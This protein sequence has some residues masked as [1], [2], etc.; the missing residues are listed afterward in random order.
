MSACFGTEMI[1]RGNVLMY[2]RIGKIRDEM[3]RN[4]DLENIWMDVGY[5][6]KSIYA[7]TLAITRETRPSQ[8]ESDAYER[9]L[10]IGYVNTIPVCTDLER[11]SISKM[12][13][14]LCREA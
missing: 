7:V 10:L 3:N 4:G 14:E 9:R 8:K 1:Y 11:N 2:L 6:N 12:L 5:V 13:Q